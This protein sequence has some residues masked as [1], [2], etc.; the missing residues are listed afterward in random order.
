MDLNG[1]LF[2]AVVIAENQDAAFIA[3]GDRLHA[4]EEHVAVLKQNKSDPTVVLPLMREALSALIQ[5]AQGKVPQNFIEMVSL[6]PDERDQ[7]VDKIGNIYGH[8][9]HHHR[10]ELSSLIHHKALKTTG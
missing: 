9:S 3:E 7:L 1:K 5:F 8:L 10:H 6:K 2:N 4:V